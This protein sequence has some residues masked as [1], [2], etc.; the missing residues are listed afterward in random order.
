MHFPED[1]P[2]LFPRPSTTIIPSHRFLSF[3]DNKTTYNMADEPSTQEIES[4]DPQVIL[5]HYKDQTS[6]CQT[7][8][9][10]ITELQMERDEHKLVI[11]TLSK[12]EPERK[13]FRLVG[14]VLVERTVEEVLPAVTQN[15]DGVCC[16]L[17]FFSSSFTY[18]CILTYFFTC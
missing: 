16:N 5:Q 3:C 14:G 11:D 8:A 13:A 4:S 17:C 1:F 12:L 18:P 2:L 7:L 15:Y 10:K 6:Q 9:N